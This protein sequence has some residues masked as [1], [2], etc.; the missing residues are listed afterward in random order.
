MKIDECKH[1]KLCK[2][3]QIDQLGQHGQGNNHNKSRIQKRAGTTINRAF[4][5]D[6]TYS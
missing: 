4:V 5:L 2:Q 6:V 1:A 3:I